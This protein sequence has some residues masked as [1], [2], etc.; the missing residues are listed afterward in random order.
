M[1]AAASRPAGVQRHRRPDRINGTPP[2]A[3]A[4][5]LGLLDALPIA[6]AIIERTAD[7][8]LRVAA[9]NNRFVEAVDKSN[10]TALDW[11]EAECLK[12]GAI[13]G[14]IQNYFDGTDT[15]GE[16]DFNQG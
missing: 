14:L 7:G 6:A 13:A 5:D 16:L 2:L 9:H 4:A 12:T 10:C 11:N 15:T 1:Q 3:A 8:N